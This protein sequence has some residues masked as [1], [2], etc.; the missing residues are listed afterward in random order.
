MREELLLVI[1]KVSWAAPLKSVSGTIRGMQGYAG[2][3][4]Q[5]CLIAANLYFKTYYCA[6]SHTRNVKSLAKLG[7]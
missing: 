7:K 5:R 3:G 2:R 6:A 4:R 1:I